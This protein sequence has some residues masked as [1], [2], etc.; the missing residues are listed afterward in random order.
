MKELEEEEKAPAARG[1]DVR[2]GQV[3]VTAAQSAD[4]SIGH[5]TTR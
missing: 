5:M 2:A 3:K 4:P 1:A